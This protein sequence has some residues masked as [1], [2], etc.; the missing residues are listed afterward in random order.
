MRSAGKYVR[1]YLGNAVHRLDN[2]F[3]T[4]F[5]GE[6]LDEVELRPGRSVRAFDI[7]DRAVARYDA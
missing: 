3:D 7:G 5:V 2:E 1:Q 4:E 6:R